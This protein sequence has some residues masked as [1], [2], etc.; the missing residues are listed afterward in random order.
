MAFRPVFF[1]TTD[2]GNVHA[3]LYEGGE[4]AV[5]LAHGRVFDKESW[6]P[7]AESL[8]AEGFTVLAIDF[9][10]YGESGGGRVTDGRHL[11]VL[12]GVG[13][14][15]ETG[16]DRVSVVGGSMGAH[17]A[18]VAAQRIPTGDIEKLVLL[19]PPPFPGADRI[20]AAEV[21]YVVGEGDPLRASVEAAFAETPEPKHLEVVAGDAHAQHLFATPQGPTVLARI[22]AFLASD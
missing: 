13:Y 18:A 17:A 6:H 15:L 21:L 1:R 7:Q 2:S 3:N 12:A 22:A 19:A 14:L 4:L 11:D 10:G 8:Q 20:R 9:R 16:L 5:V